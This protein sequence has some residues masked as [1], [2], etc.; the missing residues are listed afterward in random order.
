MMKKA[1][2]SLIILIL[3][4]SALSIVPVRSDDAGYFVLVKTYW[5]TNRPI[6][7]SPGDVATLTIVLRYDVTIAFRNLEANL[8]LPAGFEAIGEFNASTYYAPSIAQGE[9]SLVELGFPVFITLD[10]GAGNYTA[11]LDL[12]YYIS[13]RPNEIIQYEDELEIP[14]EVT[15]KPGIGAKILGDDVREGKQQVLIEMS[16]DGDAL[17]KNLEI[18]RVYS[19]SASVELEEDEFL[20][21]LDP[22][23]TAEV[24][25]DVFVPTGMKGR[26]LPLTVE[27]RY[28]GPRNVVYVFSETLQLPVKASSPVPP[29]EL[30]L[31]A[32]ELSI[33]ESS[34]VHIDLVNH[35]SH[36]VSEIK[37]TLSPDNI[38]KIFGPTVVYIDRL[39]PGESERIEAE[40]YVPSTAMVPTATLVATV[41]YFDE[42]LWVSESETQQ[43]S[44][45]LRGLI[46]MLLTDFVVI[47]ETP[48]PES[49]FSITMTVTNIGTST[50]R[51]AYAVPQ[52]EG[53]P[54]S[55][56]GSR[57]TYIGNIQTNLPTTFTV[58]LQVDN[59]TETTIVLPIT[60]SYMDNL[61]STYNVTFNIPVPVDQTSEPTQP[62]GTSSG[63]TLFGLPGFTFAVAIVGIAAIAAVIIWMWRRKR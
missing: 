6:E 23:D 3:A 29:L 31:D 59:T 60:L 61:R 22:G 8:S 38:L 15:G 9:L 36:S 18:V 2:L 50:A 41:T 25:L 58:N 43:L 44:L 16:N 63:M 57:S 62:S 10:V 30:S 7:V 1:S 51:A 46:E 26:I 4:A 32:R 56:F 5:G 53:L 35:E 49:P 19:G 55:I 47:P 27:A 48:R 14:F 13:G 28:L 40:I 54:L 24:P 39:G 21:N 37:L 42:G 52:L 33:G 12:E 17:A 20:G 11:V 45:L 34:K